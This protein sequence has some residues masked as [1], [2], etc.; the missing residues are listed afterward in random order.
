M[1]WISFEVSLQFHLYYIDIV[2]V[3]CVDTN[4]FLWDLQVW[5]ESVSRIFVDLCNQEFMIARPYVGTH[6]M[7]NGAILYTNN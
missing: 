3:L 1:S 2:I 6:K 4:H 7:T 5:I